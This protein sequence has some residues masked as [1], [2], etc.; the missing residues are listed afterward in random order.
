MMLSDK[1]PYLADFDS[2]SAML[3]ALSRF[4]HGRDFPMLGA[5]PPWAGPTV[6][7]A[8]GLVNRLPAVLREQIYIWSGWLEAIAPRRLERVSEMDLARW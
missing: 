2:A 3:S 6:K 4:L 1:P 8:C 5:V 7:A